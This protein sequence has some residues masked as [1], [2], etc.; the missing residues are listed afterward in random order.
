MT[1]EPEDGSGKEQPIEDHHQELQK[2]RDQYQPTES[3][4]N[5]GRK[6]PYCPEI[7]LG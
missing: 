4:Q 2:P 7:F 3:D 5:P 6:E 1:K